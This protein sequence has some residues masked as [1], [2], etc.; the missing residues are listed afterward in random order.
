MF[1]DFV[2][3]LIHEDFYACLALWISA[4][5]GFYIEYQLVF[6][7][8]PTL[9]IIYKY[10]AG[11]YTCNSC[12]T[13]ISALPDMYARHPRACSAWV[14]ADIS[15]NALMPVLQLICYTSGTLKINP[16][17]LFTTLPIYIRRDSN[18]DYGT[19]FQSNVSVT[20]I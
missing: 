11:Y 18:F 17:L 10:V 12:N 13:G 19:Y 7:N 5:P 2:R 20:F 9:F 8:K 4:A 15:G 3:F 1:V 14:S 16:K 6:R